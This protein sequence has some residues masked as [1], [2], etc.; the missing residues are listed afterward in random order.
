[1]L[2]MTLDNHLED[3][4]N[5]TQ[6]WSPTSIDWSNSKDDS[7]WNQVCRD[8]WVSY[9]ALVYYLESSKDYFPATDKIFFI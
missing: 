8:L 9:Q 5:K 7:G 2:T 6:W 3:H 4:E 1:M